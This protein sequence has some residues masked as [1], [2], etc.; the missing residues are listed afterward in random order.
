MIEELNKANRKIEGK[1]KIIEAMSELSSVMSQNKDSFDEDGAK[2]TWDDYM[3]VFLG[4]LLGWRFT[5]QSELITAQM[6]NT[7]M[8]GM[9]TSQ[10]KEESDFKSG[11]DSKEISS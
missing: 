2:K 6:E 3:L 7:M 9:L 1:L 4:W 8:K 10:A 5:W 11:I